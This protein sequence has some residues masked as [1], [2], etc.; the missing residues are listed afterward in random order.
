MPEKKKIFVVHDHRSKQHHFDF[1]LQWKGSLKS[2]AIP[3]KID[4]KNLTSRKLAIPTENHPLSYA[5][6][7][8]TIQ[9]GYGK[10]TVKIWDSGEWEPISLKENKWVFTLKGKRLKGTFVLV[11]FPAGWLFFKKK[12]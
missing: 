9:E 7:Q 1:R 2:W 3:K 10:G 12:S 8:G 6:F 5:S 11:R 4:P